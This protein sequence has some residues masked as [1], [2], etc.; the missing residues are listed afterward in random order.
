MNFNFDDYPPND[1]LFPPGYKKWDTATAVAHLVALMD[2]YSGLR[3]VLELACK[4]NQEEQ[5][6]EAAA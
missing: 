4:M 6:K 1:V 2:Q 5:G 3:P